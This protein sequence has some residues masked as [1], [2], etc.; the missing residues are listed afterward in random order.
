MKTDIFV[1]IL[2]PLTISEIH[3]VLMIYTSK[4]LFNVRHLWP[5]YSHMFFLTP[6]KRE[7]FIK[8]RMIDTSNSNFGNN[9]IKSK[10]GE[11]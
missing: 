4:S 11:C 1:N 8:E 7:L 6:R 9:G 10:E 2:I 3:I 5:L